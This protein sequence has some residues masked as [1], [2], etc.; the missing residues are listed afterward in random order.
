MIAEYIVKYRL[1]DK[2]VVKYLVK[3]NLIMHDDN[4]VTKLKVYLQNTVF[5]FCIVAELYDQM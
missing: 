3:Y 2:Y 4:E 1:T 5:R